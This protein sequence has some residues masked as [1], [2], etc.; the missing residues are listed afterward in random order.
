MNEP[1]QILILDGNPERP[2][3]AKVVAAIVRWASA[4]GHLI[5]VTSIL[6]PLIGKSKAGRPTASHVF[7][8]LKELRELI[9]QFPGGDEG[10][11]I[12]MGG[13]GSILHAA[14]RFH[15]YNFPVLGVNLG[16]VGFNAAVHPSGVIRALDAWRAGRY[17]MCHRLMLRAELIRKGKAVSSAV[18]LNEI[19]VERESRSRMLQIGVFQD[20]SEVMVCHADGL[21]VATPTGS[22][23]YNLAAGGPILHPLLDAVVLTPISAHTLSSRPIVLG[24]EKGLT[25]RCHIRSHSHRPYLSIDGR[26]HWPLLPGD[27]VRVNADAS[28]LKLLLP[29]EHGRHAGS[30]YFHTLREKLSW[31]RPI[32]AVEKFESAGRKPRVG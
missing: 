19:A 31:N 6:A 15:S 7:R 16:S 12:A 10:L 11:I 3:L 9:D 30:Q 22:T 20:E 5:A 13:D 2:G 1:R 26:E 17:E 8:S 28:K 18:V 4:R 14:D 32:R 25:I 23:A 29:I 27:E 21:I 24:I